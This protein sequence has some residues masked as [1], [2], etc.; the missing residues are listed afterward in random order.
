MIELYIH[1]AANTFLILIYA[2]VYITLKCIQD[3]HGHQP[4]MRLDVD[5]KYLKMCKLHRGMKCTYACICIQFRF[6]LH[7]EM[8]DLQ[9]RKHSHIK[10]KYQKSVCEQPIIIIPITVTVAQLHFNNTYAL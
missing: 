1:V 8:K 2:I 7:L 6:L 4:D 3:L 5:H 10:L 9:E